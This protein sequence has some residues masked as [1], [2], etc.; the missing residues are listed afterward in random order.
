MT[1]DDDDMIIRKAARR[2]CAE[3]AEKQDYD[4]NGKY[5]SGEWD[6]TS[7]VRIAEEGIRRGIQIGRSL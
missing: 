6:H 1:N 2:I 5:L 7:W 3:Q 4:D